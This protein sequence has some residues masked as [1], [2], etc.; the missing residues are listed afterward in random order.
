MTLSSASKQKPA[1]S[2]STDRPIGNS[3]ETPSSG[4]SRLVVERLYL[5]GRRSIAMIILSDEERAEVEG[6]IRRGK[7][8]ARNMTRA[9][10]LLKSAEGWSIEKIAATFE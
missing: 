4:Q 7:A 8:K 1:L 6:F 5:N 9:H 10:I 2:S 3:Q